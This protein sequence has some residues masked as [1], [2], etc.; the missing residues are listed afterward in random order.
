VVP[1]KIMTSQMPDPNGDEIL[2]PKLQPAERERLLETAHLLE[3]S[4][5]VPRPAFRG[6]LARQ[7]RA[8][9]A[10]PQRVRLLI[11]AY[12]GS[13]LA[14]LLVVAVGLAGVGPLAPA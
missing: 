13:G 2:D 14:L 4:R 5:P 12:A 11:G 3:R 7:L 1:D 8:R 9:S 6:K 10:G